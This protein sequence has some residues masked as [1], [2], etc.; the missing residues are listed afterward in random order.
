MRVR[1]RQQDTGSH[2]R[3]GKLL[4]KARSPRREEGD[5]PPAD[6]PEGP[7]P[8]PPSDELADEWRLRA[9]GGP[10]DRAQYA[11]VCGYVFQ[12]DVSTSVACPNCGAAQAW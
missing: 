7:L 8:E 1:A 5:A 4:G 6:E 3:G 10:A 2:R 12:A 9:A 11:C